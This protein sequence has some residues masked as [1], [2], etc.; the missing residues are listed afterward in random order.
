MVVVGTGTR[1][2]KGGRRKEIDFPSQIRSQSQMIDECKGLI[3]DSVPTLWNIPMSS[4]ASNP[5]F[6]IFGDVSQAWVSMK[7][8][9][10]AV[11]GFV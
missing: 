3:F 1:G 7:A 11:D 9:G 2:K 8:C 4:V 10:Y 6:G 5:H